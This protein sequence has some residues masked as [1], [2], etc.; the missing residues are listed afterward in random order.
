[1]AKKKAKVMLHHSGKSRPE[2]VRDAVWKQGAYSVHKQQKQATGA[3]KNYVME[4]SISRW[5]W[6]RE[7]DGGEGGS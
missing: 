2:Y 4:P 5:R 1:M 6:I 3:E 7:M